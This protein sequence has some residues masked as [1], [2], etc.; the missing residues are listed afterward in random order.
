MY[1]IRRHRNMMHPS[2]WP[3]K[4]VSIGSRV[5]RTPQNRQCTQILVGAGYRAMANRSPREP[6]IA[7]KACPVLLLEPKLMRLLLIIIILIINLPAVV[8]AAARAIVVLTQTAGLTTRPRPR[9]HPAF[10]TTRSRA[11]IWW[12]QREIKSMAGDPQVDECSGKLRSAAGGSGASG[13]S[14]T[15]QTQPRARGCVRSAG[16]V[17][18]PAGWCPGSGGPKTACQAKGM[19]MVMVMMMTTQ[20]GNS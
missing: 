9:N 8:C 2:S 4:G 15:A 1:T 18:V 20:N 7:Q 3:G 12:P 10:L 17:R 5:N 19:V 11:R 6:A 14:Q 13:H 16:E